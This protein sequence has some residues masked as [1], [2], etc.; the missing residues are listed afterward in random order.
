M[1]KHNLVS[2][3]E[4]GAADLALCD[5]LEVLQVSAQ[6]LQYTLAQPKLTFEIALQWRLS[7]TCTI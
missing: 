3:G 4:R 7:F 6:H 2:Y 5:Q 1:Q